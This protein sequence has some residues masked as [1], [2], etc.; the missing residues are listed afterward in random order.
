MMLP[1]IIVVRH[2]VVETV[3]PTTKADC[4][5]EFLARVESNVSN[6]DEYTSDDIEHIVE[7]G[8]EMFGCGSV[9]LT[10]IDVPPHAADLKDN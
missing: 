8:Y 1:Y 2:D 10:W 4:E 3:T 9:C 6:W 5:R 7:Q